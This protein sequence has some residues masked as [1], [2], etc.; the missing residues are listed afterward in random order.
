MPREMEALARAGRSCDA[1]RD[2]KVRCIRGKAGPCHRCR[3]TSHEC[4]TSRARRSRPYY[5]TSKE[6]YELMT[7]LLRHFVPDISFELHDL[8]NLVLQLGAKQPFSS[9]DDEDPS[10]PTVEPSNAACTNQS[11]HGT[12]LQ[13]IHTSGYLPLEPTLQTQI[14]PTTSEITTPSSSANRTSSLHTEVG[15]AIIASNFYDSKSFVVFLLQAR[16]LFERTEGGPHTD[17]RSILHSIQ[18]QPNVPVTFPEDTLLPV[19]SQID[20]DATAFYAEVNSVIYILSSEGLQDCVERFLHRSDICGNAHIA[21]VY[22][23]MS[24]QTASQSAFDLACHYVAPA[25]EEGSIATVEALAL[26]SLC[27]LNCNQNNLAWIHLG[28]AVR[29]AQ[30]L[31]LHADT[32]FWSHEPRSRLEHRRRLW[33]SLYDLDVWFSYYLGRPHSIDDT[34]CSAALPSE[35]DLTQV[36]HNPP[37]Y[38]GLNVHLSRLLKRFN[39]SLRLWRIDRERSSHEICGYVAEL[40]TWWD[41]LPPYFKTSASSPPSY[42][43]ALSYLH[44][45]YLHVFMILT[46]S[47]LL[48][49][50][51][52]PDIA[53]IRDNLTKAC[54]SANEESLALLHE[55]HGR[56]IISR[57]NFQDCYHILSTGLVLVVRNL[58]CPCE[59]HRS[60]LAKMRPLYI[61]SNHV[62]IGKAGSE[63]VRKFLEPSEALHNSERSQISPEDQFSLNLLELNTADIS[64]LNIF[65]TL[66]AGWMP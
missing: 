56:N 18:D 33:W 4:T 11:D 21:I 32:A 30:A 52:N 41:N 40:E 54:E 26:M 38:S 46:R 58:L 14:P 39:A 28:T 57:S 48:L 49:D 27:C 51:S 66:E 63:A 9:T 31:G 29:V 60:D 23:V 61:L 8:R 13:H 45:R 15:E 22:A 16:S 20:A 64:W 17:Q 1:C 24:L 62:T 42:A 44:L 53:R 5:Q 34:I 12:S 3:Q 7:T 37:G 6:K 59:A 43:R 2:S 50:V 65:N 10:N 55:M 47:F 19:Q 36:P 35:L 25:V